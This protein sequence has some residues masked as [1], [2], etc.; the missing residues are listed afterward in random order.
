MVA[1]PS[2]TGIVE[3]W[4]TSQ[5]APLN[6]NNP[7][8][9]MIKAGIRCRTISLPINDQTRIAKAKPTPI[10]KGA[11]IW[12]SKTSTLAMPPISPTPLP[13]DRSI[14]PGRRTSNMPSARVAVTASSIDSIDRLRGLRKLSDARAKKTQMQTS[15]MAIEK[16]RMVILLLMACSY[17][18]LLGCS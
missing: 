16:S 1:L 13:T 12:C 10:A 15:P 9:V 6:T 7:P 14:I 3:L 18:R 11:G 8:S 17:S 4:I 2:L 5:N